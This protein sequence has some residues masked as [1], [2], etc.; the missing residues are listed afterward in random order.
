M[1]RDTT[2]VRATPTDTRTNTL[3]T[4]A[5][6]PNKTGKLDSSTSNLG[7]RRNSKIHFS[8]EIEIK[9][10]E[11]K[12]RA[13]TPRVLAWDDQTGISRKPTR[14]VR[15]ERSL[16][17]QDLPTERRISLV[18]G[19]RQKMR[20][21]R[22]QAGQPTGFESIMKQIRSNTAAYYRYCLLRNLDDGNDLIVPELVRQQ[23]LSER[24]PVKIARELFYEV[25]GGLVDGTGMPLDNGPKFTT[26]QII[27]R[28]VYPSRKTVSSSHD[29][30]QTTTAKVNDAQ[31]CVSSDQGPKAT[32]I[33]DTGAA[34]HCRNLHELTEQQRAKIR[35]LSEPIV[36][37][38]ANGAIVVD[39][40]IETQLTKLGGART[41][42]MLVMENSPNLLSI[43]RLVLE[44][45]Y[46][47]YWTGK[48][49][50]LVSPEGDHI[51]LKTNN[52]VPE[53]TTSEHLVNKINELEAY[54]A[55]DSRQCPST[56]PKPSILKP[57]TGDDLN[58]DLF[59]IEIFAGTKRLS[60]KISELANGR[61]QVISIEIKD[62]PGHDLLN[63]DCWLQ[64][65]QLTNSGKCI[66]VWM[67]PPCS[68]WSIA[69]KQ[70]RLPP[71]P[72]RNTN[73]I[74]GLHDLPPRDLKKMLDANKLMERC[75][76]VAVQ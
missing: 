1:V 9:N 27:T 54:Q 33:G 26:S 11:P 22:G 64:I 7:N 72:L 70:S 10:L 46:K 52:Y 31:A 3:G 38:T 53:L 43:G 39:T 19:L 67:A 14:Y 21:S 71:N 56:T 5:L 13:T 18:D 8:R 47:F 61:I 75:Y 29:S 2:T 57:L 45:G 37:S 59:F 4:S 65:Q 50:H 58:D 12:H 25:H 40:Y 55:M 60:K 69:M 68:T 23:Y 15:Q 62:D 24:D 74:H 28:T 44:D 42:K 32:L 30:E 35:Q 76:Q 63:D 49:A 66:G 17:K 48:Q 51:W 20:E 36:L 6:R 16:S 73:N 34:Y 41:V